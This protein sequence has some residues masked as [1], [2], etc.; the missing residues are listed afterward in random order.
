MANMLDAAAKNIPPTKL[1]AKVAGGINTVDSGGHEKTALKRAEVEQLIAQAKIEWESTADS[2]PQMVFLLDEQGRVVRAN[3]TVERWG[4]GRVADIKGRGLHDLMHPSCNH[5][6]CYL[7]SFLECASRELTFKQ[8]AECE[9]EDSVLKRHLQIQLR[10]S[11]SGTGRQAGTR[12]PTVAVIHDITDIKHTEEVLKKFNEELEQRVESRTSELVRANTML[13]WEMEER[14][15][16][17]GVLRD[18]GIKLR[19]LSSELL[20]TE[21]KERKRIASELHDGIGQ[22]LSAVKFNVENAVRLLAEK[23][24]NGLQSLEL[25]VKHIQGAIEEVR[26]ISMNLRPTTLDDLGILPTIAWFMREYSTTYQ[27][28]KIEKNI[29]VDEEDVPNELKTVMFR[30]MQEAMNNIAKHS[31]ASLVLVGLTKLND[32]M[33]LTIHDN[34]KGFKPDDVRTRTGSHGGF[35]L[36]IMKERAEMSGG[37]YVLQS[38]ENMGTR[39]RAAWAYCGPDPSARKSLAKRPM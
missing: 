8:F 14:K 38:A 12:G 35:G 34:G 9:S 39:I 17:E 30:I 23:N 16:A 28:I 4:V 20:A 19:V 13:K 29:T 24:T 11:L 22:T 33:E 18:S 25:V 26:N 2:L 6:N 3:R 10:T 27:H 32:V 5:G 15:R 31:D 7:H 36:T 37:S 1:G 21:E